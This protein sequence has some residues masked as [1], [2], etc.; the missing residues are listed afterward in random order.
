M[1]CYRVNAPNVIHETIDGEAVVVNLRSGSYYSID[2]VGAAVW[3]CIE[4]GL[5]VTGIVAVIAGDYR[6]EAGDIADGVR[7]LLAQLETE[8]L[9]VPAEPA[10]SGAALPASN[11][12]VDG[13]RPHFERPVLHKYTDMEDLLLLDPIHDVGEKGWPNTPDKK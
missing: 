5:S 1:T 10:P 11:G 8:E 3:D 12:A 2:K 9:I 13:D 7:Q 4:K 6:G